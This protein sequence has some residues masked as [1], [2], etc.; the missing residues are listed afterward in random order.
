MKIINRKKSIKLIGILVALLIFLTT[1]E[2]AMK[3]MS[4]YKYVG[5]EKKH[6][7]WE[8]IAESAQGELSACQLDLTKAIEDKHVAIEAANPDLK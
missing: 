6:G 2:I 7:S 4:D 5:F 1:V 3:F 8:Q